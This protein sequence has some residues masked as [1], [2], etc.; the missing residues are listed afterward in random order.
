MR[1]LI[2]KVTVGVVIGWIP[3]NIFARPIDEKIEEK[4]EKIYVLPENIA[5]HN[6]TIFVNLNSEWFQTNALFSD[7]SGVYVQSNSVIGEWQCWRCGFMN[8]PWTLACHKCG[9]PR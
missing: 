7:N 2:V 4:V 5:V 9:N 8:M 6:N 3:V 1:K